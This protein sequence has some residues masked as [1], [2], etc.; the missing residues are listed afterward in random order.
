MND[1]ELDRVLDIIHQARADLVDPPRL[2]ERALAVP[3]QFPKR[4]GWPR[5]DIG[6]FDM[7]SALKFVAAAAIVALF[8]GFLL[9][10]GV[11][12]PQEKEAAP[13]AATEAV[14]D[15]SPDV[16]YPVTVTGSESCEDHSGGTSSSVAGVSSERGWVADC[17]NAMSDP[18]VD[19]TWVNTLNSDCYLGGICV[20][21]GTHVLEV[22]DGGWDCTWSG[23]NYAVG[24]SPTRILGI[25]PGTGGFEGWTYVFQHRIAD[26]VEEGPTYDGVIY[27][28]PAPTIYDTSGATGSG[29]D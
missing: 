12:T 5:I 23:T 13:A 16:T 15:A 18:R 4:H 7:S 24:N 3:S 26:L 19:G 14:Q 2:H 17:V 29:S 8:G 25:C 28:G 11:P 21:W 6:G 10:G 20:F 9:V 22:P 1:H 27:E